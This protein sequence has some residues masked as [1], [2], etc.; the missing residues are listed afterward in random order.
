MENEEAAH[1]EMKNDKS[2]MSYNLRHMFY[3]LN[4]E[5]NNNPSV[6]RYSRNIKQYFSKKYKN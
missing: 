6:E 3:Q 4:L 2:T 5:F 1:N